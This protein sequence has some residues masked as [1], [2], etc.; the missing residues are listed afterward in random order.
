MLTDGELSFMRKSVEQLLPDT[1]NILSLTNTP[2]GQGGQTQTWGT[3]SANVTCRLDVTESREMNA[4][5]AIQTFT[6]YKLSMP[7]DTTIAAA[8]R[9][10]VN[11]ET[12]T[13]IGVN[14][15]Q[16]WK[17]VTRVTLELV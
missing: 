10:E 11:G 14:N 17:A 4:A 12:Y 3:A 5:G 6:T 9:V 2:D 16:S 13:V 15:G 7:Y 8:N 1:C